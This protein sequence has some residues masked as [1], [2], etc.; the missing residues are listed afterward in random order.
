MNLFKV[1]FEEAQA[2]SQTFLDYINGSPNLANFYNL[3]PEL[4]SFLPQIEQKKASTKG[5]SPL[6]RQTLQ[7]VLQKQYASIENPPSAQINSLTQEN[8]FTV[9]TGHQL[10]LFTG[11]L[12]FIYKICTTIRLSEVLH[13][14]YPEYHFVPVYWMATEDHDFAE[15]NHFNLFN[16]TFQWESAQQGPVGHFKLEELA[17][18]L[19]DLPEKLP[20]FEKAYR[21][22]ENL[23]QATRL[24][25]HEL[26]Q[27]EKLICLDADDPDLKA[28]YKEV[29]QDD[30]FNQQADR[31]VKAT[32]LQLD[33][34]G[35]KTQVSPREINLFYL[36]TGLRERI[37]KNGEGFE[38]LNTDIRFSH[39][40]IKQAIEEKPDL[41]SPNVILRPLYQEYI[42]PNLAYIGGPSELVY[43]LQLKAVFE[44]YKTPFP[45]L[46]P[47]NFALVLNKANSK[48]YHKLD[49]K[50][51][52]LFLDI[53]VLKTQYL[54]A[55]AEG[56]I[57]LDQELKELEEVF[58]K[59]KNKAV[60]VD[61]TLEGYLGAERNKMAKAFQNIAKR[62]KKAEEQ[63]HQKD[64]NQLEGLKNKLFP[65]G[66]LQERKENILNFLINEPQ[67]I[68]NIQEKFDPLDF[69]MNVFIQESND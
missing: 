59:I 19:Q 62:L 65:E 51:Q 69:Q 4:A 60:Q 24:L 53:H 41:F 15:I 5:Q 46:I 17:T 49:L 38:V 22:S 11:P 34:L 1:P 2:F 14:T 66:S 40:E 6:H 45:L 7:K 44:Y 36:Q 63:K 48:K 27:S 67:F 26:F 29:I 43:W 32:S 9:T 28:L 8:T 18:L 42:L 61:S 57:T 21:E 12:Y 16:K 68:Q 58:D 13:E 47:R 52:D 56:E 31:L 54:E 33:N 37:V 3:R 20:L 50:P 35:Y 10:N 25:V 30:I 55:N 23:A 64:I 39:D